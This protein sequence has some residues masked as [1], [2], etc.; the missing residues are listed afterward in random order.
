MNSDSFLTA[1]PQ[2][3]RNLNKFLRQ[4]VALSMLGMGCSAK[5]KGRLI[6]ASRRN[7]P[8][9]PTAA[10]MIKRCRLPGEMIRLIVGRTN[11][12]NE[13]DM[14]CS[15][16]QRPQQRS[17]FQLIDFSKIGIADKNRIHH[18]ALGHLRKMAVIDDIQRLARLH[19]G[20]PPSC[21]MMTRSVYKYI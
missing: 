1:V 7:I 3:L 11:R 9:C 16:S 18:S 19:A 6:G 13:A 2:L 15:S 17:R 21:L 10:N 4:L 8:T 14:P 12:G 20:M 5:I